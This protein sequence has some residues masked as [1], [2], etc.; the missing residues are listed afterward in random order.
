KLVFIPVQRFLCF[1]LLP[2]FGVVAV[3]RIEKP[4]LLA[5]KELWLFVIGFIVVKNIIYHVSLLNA[6]RSY[7]VHASQFSS[8]SIPPKLVAVGASSTICIPL[9][10]FWF[11]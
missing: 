4:M 10:V 2:N 1:I 3:N 7:S 11:M 6:A 9:E 8:S 5:H